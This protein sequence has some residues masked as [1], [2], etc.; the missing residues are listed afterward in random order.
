MI[1][2]A[3][4][5]LRIRSAQEDDA[6]R[7]NHWWNDGAVMAHAGFPDGLKQ[8]L[9]ETVEGIRRSLAGGGWL[10]MME[11]DGVPIGECALHVQDG[12]GMPGS[13]I[14]ETSWQN[15]GLGPHF[16]SMTMDYYFAQP[17]LQVVRWDT[18]LDNL[19]AQKVYERL[20]GVKRLAVQE[21]AW[22]D[23]R[24]VWRS[25]VLYELHKEDW[26]NAEKHRP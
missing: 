2:L 12:Q 14:C 4:G 3:R 19:R 13:K 18:M 8:P 17:N 16:I 1:A 25:A 24:G 11:A 5:F 26:L 23:Q 10:C 20:P 21:N 7:L 15:R 9:S 6:P 22:R